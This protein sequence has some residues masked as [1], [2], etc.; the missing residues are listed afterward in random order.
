MEVLSIVLFLFVVWVGS[1]VQA[2]AGFAMAMLIVAIVGGLRLLDVPTLAA[3]VSLL[4]IFN[5]FI[6][7]YGNVHHINRR[8]FGWIAVGQIPA[9]FVGLELMRWLDGNTRAVLEI[10]LGLFITMGGL[11]MFLHPKPQAA[12]SSRFT[13]W[14]TGVCGGLV[15][16]MFSASGPVLGWFAYRQ[17]LPLAAIRATLL[18]CFV[19]TTSSRTILV[20]IEGGLTAQVL[21]YA[22]LGL[23]VVLL[24]T[25]MGR[26]FAAPVNEEIIRR[27]AYLLLLSMGA[28]ILATSVWRL[29]SAGV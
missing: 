14:M 16:G 1:Y 10:C 6:A 25:W 26:R 4:T 18:A 21:R 15:G 13:C 20:G 11:S 5:V 28:W 2:V 27:A 22:G 9:I 12:I 19:L 3:V 29:M 23:P 17:P 8:V 24:G 7:L